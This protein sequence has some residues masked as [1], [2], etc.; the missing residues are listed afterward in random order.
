[1]PEI[2]LVRVEG[3]SFANG[4]ELSA[5]RFVHEPN[6][7]RAAKTDSTRAVESAWGIG[8]ALY[9]YAGHAC[10]E[11]GQVVLVYDAAALAGPGT[12]TPFDSG[13]LYAGFVQASGAATPDERKAYFEA[14]RIDLG[15]MAAQVQTYVGAHFGSAEEYVRGVPA[16]TDDS[17]GR[18]LHPANQR[19]AWTWEAQVLR[20]HGLHDGL[21]LCCL[22]VDFHD[23]VRR[24][25]LDL[26]DEEAEALEAFLD[27]KAL[28]VA[29]VDDDAPII[30]RMAEQEIASWL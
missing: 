4:A 11:F 28:R 3:K 27:S 12:A 17:T 19:R 8:D 6:L 22:P 24:H 2:P 9:L 7:L 21:K 26:P 1:M 29:D 25:V 14:H 15:G 10:P 30:A 20:D 18:L 16:H 5:R 23:A 13:G